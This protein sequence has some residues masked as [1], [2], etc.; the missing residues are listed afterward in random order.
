MKVVIDHAKFNLWLNESEGAQRGL[1]STAKAF[2]EAAAEA[3]PVGT[4]LSW[5]K[6]VPG[7]PW[8][9][10]PMRH[11]LF[12]KA[13]QTRRFRNYYRVVNRDNF[14]FLVEYGSAKNQ[15]YAPIRR[16]LRAFGGKE[17]AKAA[18]PDS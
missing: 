13:F 11:G 14:A 3:S 8:V 6:K 17:H 1:Y 12:K 16:T 10:R 9:R 2:E 15:P 7:E 4:S 5:P 18:S